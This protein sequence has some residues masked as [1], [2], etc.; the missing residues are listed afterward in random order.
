LRSLKAHHVGQCGLPEASRSQGEQGSWQC[1]R[2]SKGGCRGQ[3]SPHPAHPLHPAHPRRQAVFLSCPAVWLTSRS[4]YCVVAQ[5]DDSG[6]V[7]W[8]LFV[9]VCLL[10]CL[11]NCV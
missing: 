4:R 11:C 3:H 9:H 10:A 1:N 6:H 8:G 7:I 2:C 5:S